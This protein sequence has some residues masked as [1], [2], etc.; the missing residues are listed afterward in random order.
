MFSPK[1]LIKIITISTISTLLNDIEES[2]RK[3]MRKK[4]ID[5]LS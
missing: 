4:D 3:R 1:D 2:V 5:T